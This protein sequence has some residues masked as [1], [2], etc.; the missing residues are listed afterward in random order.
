MF[1]KNIKQ[2][3][4]LTP[5]GFKTFS[6]IRMKESKII[7]FYFIDDKFIDVTED[8]R[9]VVDGEEK[10]AINLKIG[11][12]LHHKKLG[13]IKITN[14]NDKIG[15]KKVYDPIDVDGNLYYGNDILNHNCD[16]LGSTNTVIN[17]TTLEV[18]LSSYTDPILNDLGGRLLVYENPIKDQ[19]YILGVDPAKGTG[20]NYSVIQILKIV[21][22]V[23]IK[24]EQVGIFR[25][26][27]TDVYELSNIIDRLSN[28]YNKAYIMCENN[29]EGSAVIQRLWWEIENENL[30][31]T[32]SKAINLG[33]RSSRTTKPRAVLLMKKIIESGS[34]KLVDRNT[35]EELSSYIE[36]NNK[37]FG[38]DR[39]DDCVSGLY[40]GLYIFEMDILD[41]SFK[42]KKESEEEDTW[43]I[44]VDSK[45][46]E[47]QDWDW[48]FN[49]TWVE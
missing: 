48:L 30:V 35:V 6:G 4:I 16:F 25:D 8:H 37:F 45:S 2:Y 46:K 47:D 17:T 29:G 3:K 7:R 42:F 31:N 18:L 40:I 33:I 15:I 20:E 24:I 21:S 41:E 1:K 12:Y 38:K 26:N 19:Q 36:E 43:G 28:Y 34:I 9:F 32:G 13:N 22:M 10:I 23:P 14:I 39:L 11:D 49:S 44:L 5:N 27:L